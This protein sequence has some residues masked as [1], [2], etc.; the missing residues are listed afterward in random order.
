MVLG[1]LQRPVRYRSFAVNLAQFSFEGL[2]CVEV[3]HVWL[4]ME[5]STTQPTAGVAGDEAVD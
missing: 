3:H 1:G 2:E 4:R 5:S